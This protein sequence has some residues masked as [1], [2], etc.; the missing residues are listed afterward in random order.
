MHGLNARMSASNT[1]HIGVECRCIPLFV[2]MGPRDRAGAF[3]QTPLFMSALL[4]ALGIASFVKMWATVLDSGSRTRSGSL[5]A[6][7]EDDARARAPR[8]VSISNPAQ[9]KAQASRTTPQRPTCGRAIARVVRYRHRH[10]S[11][12]RAGRSPPKTTWNRATECS[13]VST[14]GRRSPGMESVVRPCGRP[15]R[16]TNVEQTLTFFPRRGR[17]GC[18]RSAARTSSSGAGSTRAAFVGPP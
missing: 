14:N 9:Q 5:A 8:D 1:I 4:T 13:S 16:A 12:A 18:K 7:W 6:C 3:C 11:A 10:T 15:S 2:Q 17:C